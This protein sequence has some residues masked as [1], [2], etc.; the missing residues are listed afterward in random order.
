MKKRLLGKTG[1]AISELGYGCTALFGKNVLGSKGIDDKKAL[2]LVTTALETG[3]NFL[4]TGFNYGYA[5]ERLGRCLFEIINGGIYKRKDL[6]I[7]TKCGE[8]LNSD[9]TYGNKD[10]SP[11]WIKKSVEISLKRLQLD[12]IDLLAMHG[13]EP[14]M[15]TDPLLYLFEDYKKYGI[16]KAYGVSGVSND[17]GNWICEHN[18]FDYVMLT[19]NFTEARRNTLIKKLQDSGIGVITGGSL[20]QSLND[21]WHIPR[22][23]SELWYMARALVQFRSKLYRS[24]KFDFIKEIKGMS[25]QQASLAYILENKNI[26]SAVFNTI[27]VEHLKDNVKAVGMQLPRD[28]K[29]KIENI[30]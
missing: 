21:I 19:Y 11:D 24:K 28:I 14:D 15:V 22:T 3:I 5:E 13:A 17:F 8:L 25:I 29:N 7:Q 4:D 18:V 12:Y 26:C 16:I 9:G 27:S 2:S 30:K 20:N 6:I 1:I 10:Y 23:K